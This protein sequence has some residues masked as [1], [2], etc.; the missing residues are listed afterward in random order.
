MGIGV[1]ERCD[2]AECSI[3]DLEVSYYKFQTT[4]FPFSIFYFL[5]FIFDSSCWGSAKTTLLQ[6]QI[7]NDKWKMENLKASK[8]E[9]ETSIRPYSLRA[10]S[11]VV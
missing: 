11:S 6:W 2:S 1:I 7:E 4:D 9:T 3:S 5:F 10:R 8:S